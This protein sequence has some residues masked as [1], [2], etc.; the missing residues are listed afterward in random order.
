[1]AGTLGK[2]EATNLHDAEQTGPLRL[3]TA[4]EFLLE[5]EPQT[6]DL[7]ADPKAAIRAECAKARVIAAR[8]GIEGHVKCDWSPN[9]AMDG[10]ALLAF[11]AYLWEIVYS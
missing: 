6:L 2:N 5:N 9:H 4:Y 1:M 11:P 3:M 8:L 7:Y 10:M